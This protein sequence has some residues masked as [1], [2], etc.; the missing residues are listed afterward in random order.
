MSDFPDLVRVS[1]S[2]IETSAKLL[3]RAFQDDQ[4]SCYFFPDPTE[5]KKRLPEFFN[6]RV[7]YAVLYGEVYATSSSMEGLA[8][9][10]HSDNLASTLWKTMRSGGLKLYRVMGRELIGR[11]LRID[12]FVNEYHSELISGSYW[13][14]GPL[15]VDPNLQGK[16]HASRLIRPMLERLD[17]EGTRCFLETQNESIISLYEHYGFEVAGSC[18]VPDANILHWGMIRHPRKP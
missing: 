15:G 2:D 18:T 4:M 12:S 14:L 13:Y 3:A 9:W 16:G 10:T 11:M 1:K 7:R 5:R 8:V 6:Y 17:V